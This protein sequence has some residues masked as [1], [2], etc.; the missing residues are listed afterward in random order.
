MLVYELFFYYFEVFGRNQK[1]CVKTNTVFALPT[2]SVDY[3]TFL[4]TFH[5][6]GQGEPRSKTLDFVA[7]VRIG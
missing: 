5:N 3:V 7:F 6:G 4:F 2:G 1:M